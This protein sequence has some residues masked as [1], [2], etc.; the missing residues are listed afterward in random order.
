MKKLLL[1][2]YLSKEFFKEI[3][4]HV[5]RS[6]DLDN[7]AEAHTYFVNQLIKSPTHR[8]HDSLSLKINSSL[9]K[10]IQS[11]NISPR[12]PL[13]INENQKKNTEGAISLNNKD[14]CGI[15]KSLRNSSIIKPSQTI[16]TLSSLI[17]TNSDI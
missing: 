8:K 15:L 11:K 3:K 17:N 1:E 12:S 6:S 2:D 10:V 5:K 7:D 4:G 9:I 13:K 16:H 14:S